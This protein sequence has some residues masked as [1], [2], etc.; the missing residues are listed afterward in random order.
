MRQT[1]LESLIEVNSNI[2]IGYVASLTLWTFFIVPFY[3]LPVTI[4]QNLEITGWFTILAIVRGYVIRR[5]FN[6]GLHKAAHKLAGRILALRW[7]K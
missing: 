5:F 7:L 1:K 4:M 6:A 3:N 2:A